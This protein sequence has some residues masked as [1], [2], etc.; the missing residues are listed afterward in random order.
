MDVL[1]DELRGEVFSNLNIKDII[2]SKNINKYYHKYLSTN[3][4][5]L[6]ILTV[7]HNYNI[8]LS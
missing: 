7:L 6:Y 2:Y 8:D 3:F 1:F 4:F 5:G